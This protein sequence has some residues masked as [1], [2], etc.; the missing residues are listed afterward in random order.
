MC[1][2][3][4]IALDKDEA[5]AAKWFRASAQSKHQGAL[6][7]LMALNASSDVDGV[8]NQQDLELEMQAALAGN[9][10]AAFLTGRRY[11][12]GRGR[13]KDENIARTWY[14]RASE[15]E[16]VSQSALLELHSIFREGRLGIEPDL[17]LAED[18]YARYRALSIKEADEQGRRIRDAALNGDRISQSLLALGYDEGVFGLPRSENRAAFWRDL[19]SRVIQ[20]PPD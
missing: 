6:N 14:L 20:E 11:E 15:V 16:P 19:A 5:L 7:E 1:Y 9:S 13:Q 17:E 18:Y 12:S 10:F 8:P 4:G 2:W 3:Q